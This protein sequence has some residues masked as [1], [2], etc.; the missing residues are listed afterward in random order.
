M[1]DLINTLLSYEECMRKSASIE[2]RVLWQ[3]RKDLSE[4]EYMRARSS[5]LSTQGICWRTREYWRL[6][7]S[8]LDIR[9]SPEEL[10]ASFDKLSRQLTMETVKPYADS[11]FVLKELK[12]RRHKLALV[13]NLTPWEARFIDDFELGPYFDSIVVSSLRGVK[14]PDP[15]AF[16]LA[17]EELG[18]SPAE[19]AMIGDR[20][21]SDIA[22]AKNLGMLTIRTRRG[23]FSNQLPPSDP[24]SRPDYE[25]KVLKEVLRI[26]ELKSPEA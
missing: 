25:L 12:L 1:I 19:A 7:A 4:G 13:T 11:H 22:P 3:H 20:Y 16:L 24:F 17:L 2:L 14:K 10:L 6:L 23:W 18:G 8:L 26:P 15:Q 5:A 9:K 21:D